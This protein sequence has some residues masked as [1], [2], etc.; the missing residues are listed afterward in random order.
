M[1]VGNR[2]NFWR[3]GLQAKAAV[4]IGADA[5]VKR[6]PRNLADVVNVVDN[7][8]QGYF[9]ASVFSRPATRLSGMC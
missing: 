3:D 4:E 5:S 2:I 6:I 7:I 8:T 9:L 1:Q